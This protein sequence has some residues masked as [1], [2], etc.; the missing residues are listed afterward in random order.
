[1]VRRHILLTAAA[2]ILLAASA[3]AQGQVPPRPLPVP[4][5]AQIQRTLNAVVLCQWPMDAALPGY[6]EFWYVTQYLYKTYRERAAAGSQ[7]RD[8]SD[9]I[10]TLGAFEVL[11]TYFDVVKIA[12]FTGGGVGIAW[13]ASGDKQ[14]LQAVLREQG[15]VFNPV[16]TPSGPPVLEGRH[17]SETGTRAVFIRDGRQGLDGKVTPGGFTLLCRPDRPGRASP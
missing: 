17:T 14:A 11:G 6:G 15:Y 8:E 12:G 4:D 10:N 5:A 16:N 9:G 7:E 3:H 1:M 2:G 13:S